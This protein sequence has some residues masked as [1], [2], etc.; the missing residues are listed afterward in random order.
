MK[1]IIDVLHLRLAQGW[2]K[3]R[4]GVRQVVVI[5]MIRVRLQEMN[6]SQCNVSKGDVMF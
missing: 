1:K 3:V 5:V 6:L 4:L 2:E